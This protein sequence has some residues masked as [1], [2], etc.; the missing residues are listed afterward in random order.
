MCQNKINRLTAGGFTIYKALAIIVPTP[1][2]TNMKITLT[3]DQKKKDKARFGGKTLSVYKRD[4]YQCVGCAMT[5]DQHISKYGKRLTI[6]HINGLGRNCI[7]PDNSMEN[8]ETVCLPCHG[9]RDCMNDKWLK[10]NGNPLNT[11]TA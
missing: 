2:T 9:K 5:M 4:N 10:S 8:L 6:N 11:K 1:Y 7:E 3:R